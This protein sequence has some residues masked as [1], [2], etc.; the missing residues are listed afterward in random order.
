MIEELIELYHATESCS[1]GKCCKCTRE[2]SLKS[3]N[4]YPCKSK[5][6]NDCNVIFNNLIDKYKEVLD[7]E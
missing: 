7:N 3:S 5:L 6:L 2:N 1:Q 4:T